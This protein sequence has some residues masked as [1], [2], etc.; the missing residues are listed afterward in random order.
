MAVITSQ[1][2]KQTTFFQWDVDDTDLKR[3]VPL[4]KMIPK[5]PYSAK[6]T[7]LA[8]FHTLLKHQCRLLQDLGDLNALH[9]YINMWHHRCIN[10]KMYDTEVV[11]LVQKSANMLLSGEMKTSMKYAKQARCQAEKI[12]PEFRDFLC[13]LTSATLSSRYKKKEKLGKSQQYLAQVWYYSE[14]FQEGESFGHAYWSEGGY[15]RSILKTCRNNDGLEYAI[16]Y[17]AVE[18]YLKAIDHRLYMPDTDIFYNKEK[19]MKSFTHLIRKKLGLTGDA[20]D[21]S[22]HPI[23]AKDIALAQKCIEMLSQFYE[24]FSKRFI[25]EGSLE[26]DFFTCHLSVIWCGF[27]WRK[28]EFMMGNSYHESEAETALKRCFS[29][30]NAAFHTASKR[31]FIDEKHEAE[32]LLKL[33]TKTAKC[34]INVEKF[35]HSTS[36]TPGSSFQSSSNQSE[37]N[38]IKLAIK[39][40][41]YETVG[42]C[43]EELSSDSPG[44]PSEASSDIL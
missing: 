23:T 39:T 22:R 8:N 37:G 30:G 17:K 4:Y 16:W 14:P 28:A 43:F 2:H 34:P 25:R 15:Y 7:K 11:I 18:S 41:D 3:H 9:H 26:S 44:N 36:E 31:Q 38:Q 27:Y 24:R 6:L 40:S 13:V 12:D 19:A 29:Y 10:N 33:A 35:D 42:V 5:I 20:T 21:Y 1:M 32:K